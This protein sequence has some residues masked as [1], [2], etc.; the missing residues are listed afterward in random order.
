M[1][2]Q[3][4]ARTK[5]TRPPFPSAAAFKRLPLG[6]M[7]IAIGLGP[8]SANRPWWRCLQA[9]TW[10]PIT[11][12]ITIAKADGDLRYTYPHDG[13]PYQGTVHHF[14]DGGPLSPSAARLD[15]V[16][17]RVPGETVT[18]YVNPFDPADSVLS[19]SLNMRHSVLILNLI[20]LAVF[21]IP[22]AVLLTLSI[23]RLVAYRR[24]MRPFALA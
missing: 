17:T 1:P 21:C 15:F 24:A 19:R 4:L 5:R 9:L 18:A 13:V 8:I 2:R 7:L 3:Q 16:R 22:G 12:T 11:A 10:T 6:L 20:F 23:R 14:N